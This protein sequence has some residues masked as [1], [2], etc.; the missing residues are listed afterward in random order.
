MTELNR[1]RVLITGA[2]GFLGSRLCRE[3]VDRENE[4]HALCRP[5]SGAPL[6]SARPWE[7]ALDDHA[8]IKDL[9]LSIKPDFIF[10]LA[11]FTSASREVS[12]VLPAF[13]ANLVA[14]INLLTAFAE[15]GGERM[16]LAGSFEDPTGGDDPPSSPYAASKW[17][18]S[19]YARMFQRLYQ[20]PVTLAR[21]FMV[22][23][24]GQRDTT[25]LIPSS[26]LSALG[27]VNPQ[28]GSGTREVDWIYVDDVISGLIALGEA[29]GV[30]GQ[31]V[32][33]GT[34]VLTSVR[35][36]VEKISNRINPAVQPVMGA[37]RDRPDEQV[38][39]AELERTQSLLGWKPKVDLEEGLRRTIDYYREHLERYRP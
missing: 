31:G 30:E 4:V 29:E 18:G 27:G 37:V 19:G 24:P 21:I 15:A 17:A 39:A 5:G 32:D 3:L 34:G 1:R 10:H 2:T 38:R 9:L 7:C 22:Y 23:G 6:E 36:V 20:T 33:I 16:V 11:G 25:K 14:T 35:E 13:H 28:I 26:I 12:A 8:K